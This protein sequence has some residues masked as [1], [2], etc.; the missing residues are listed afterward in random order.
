MILGI[1]HKNFKHLPLTESIEVA[2]PTIGGF[3]TQ[4]SPFFGF[5]L[6]VSQEPH[7]N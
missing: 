7:M 2:W 5:F 6:R 4:E 1:H 3:D